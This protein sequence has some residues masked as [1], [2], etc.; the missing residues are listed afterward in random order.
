MKI[1]LRQI[2]KTKLLEYV[3]I[4][5][6]GDAE[7]LDKYHVSPGTL[8]HC[9]EHTMGFI[10][11][12]ENFYKDDIEYYA[13]ILDNETIIGYTIIIVNEKLPN[14]LYSF[15]INIKYRTKEIVLLWLKAAERLLAIPYYV[16][17]WSKNTRAIEFFEKNGFIVERENK[18]L[19]DALK[20]LI[21]CPREVC[22]SERQ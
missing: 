21:I 18:Q 8:D 14:E 9:V 20:T 2:C 22:L 15:A 4:G 6:E 16:V 11:E 13:I 5:F 19:N 12:N 17:L 1:R 7:L 3:R 10:T